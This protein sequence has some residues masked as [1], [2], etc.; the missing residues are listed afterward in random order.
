LKTNETSL[1]DSQD[2]LMSLIL[3]APAA[4]AD[5]ATANA[6]A[7]AGAGRMDYSCNHLSRLLL[8]HVASTALA[9]TSQHF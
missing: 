7:T 2:N 4:T 8:G 5:V 3:V 6:T 1:S 9:G